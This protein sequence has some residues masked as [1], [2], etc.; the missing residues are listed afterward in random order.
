M[1][2]WIAQRRVHPAL[3]VGLFGLL[4]LIFLTSSST[5]LSA[6]GG[7]WTASYWNNR[8][9]SGSPVLV[10]SES[11]I[12]YDWGEGSPAPEVQADNFS[13]EWTQTANLP[14]GTYRFSATTDDGMR[15][16]V[17]NTVVIESWYDGQVRTVTSDVYLGA[18]NHTV[19]VQY[20][21][22]GGMAVARFSMTLVSGV[23]AP[24]TTAWLGE[25]FN[26]TNLAGTPVLVRNDP[27]I[28][29]NWGFGSPAVGVQA[30]AFSV[31]WSRTLNLN[32]GRYRFTTVT[33]DGVRL[34]V[35]GV[36]VLDKWQVQAAT[37]YTVDIDIP[38]GNTSVV[39]DYFEAAGLA[40]ARLGWTQ[41]SG[42]TPPPPTPAPPP[43]GQWQAEYFGNTTLTGAPLLTRSEAAINYD[44]GFGSPAPQVPVDN[45]SARWTS[46]VNLPAGRYQFRASTDDGV[47]VFVNDTVVID[48]WFDRAVADFTA[49]KD[50]SGPTTIRVEY[51]ERTGVAVA[52]VSYSLVGSIPG[53]GGQGSGSATVTASTL[54][55]RSGPSASFS[56]IGQLRNGAT[57]PLTGYRNGDGSWVQIVMPTGATGWVNAT[58]VRTSVPVSSLIP[59]TGTTPPP[60]TGGPPVGV[61]MAYWL[62]ARTGPSVDFPVI[63][64]LRGGT[65]VALIGRDARSVW[66]KIFLPDGRQGWVNGYYIDSNVP[67]S[68]L[69]VLTN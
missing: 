45:F 34:T 12:N 17:D 50:L 40:E 4:A 30:D 32:P 8:T 27:A 59:I 47:R 41:L 38:G 42:T 69:P 43:T 39:M 22:A 56:I 52:K 62:N 54:N 51:Y 5:N 29:F 25:Y 20:Y 35:N 14:A 57:V 1:K 66:L 67:V 2:R 3:L 28:N 64:R 23:P 6:Q 37:A 44:W 21:E 24:P 16:F 26:N 31:R 19:K 36:R 48:A 58:Y 65:R 68:T 15:V 49:E 60:P 61:V 33:D 46:S 53:T 7:S 11:S 18:G 55:V 13:A 9:L 63:T 10:R